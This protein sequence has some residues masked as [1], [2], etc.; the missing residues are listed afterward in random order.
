[1]NTPHS[2]WVDTDCGI[3]DA[4]ALI[5]L[6]AA[7]VTPAGISSVTGNTT[8]RQAAA[9]AA[10][11]LRRLGAPTPV[12]AGLDV[13]SSAGHHGTD[14]LG[15]TG[16]GDDSAV[17]GDDGVDALLAHVQRH[18]GTALLALGPATNLATALERDPALARRLGA[19]VLVAGAAEDQRDTNTA[20]DPAAM[21]EVAARLGPFGRLTVTTLSAT[22][23]DPI[24]GTA[25]ARLRS[26]PRLGGI[27]RPLVD[28]FTQRGDGGVPRLIAH[29]A[30]AAATLLRPG[31]VAASRHGDVAV[32][33]GRLV[34]YGSGRIRWVTALRGAGDR[35]VGTLGT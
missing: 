31:T 18:P 27:V 12:C 35:L 7:G 20:V 13:Q 17:S 6:V 8:A 28:A 10:G 21:A 33:D 4:L 16:L 22:A 5:H 23:S 34:P 32:R 24:T 25:L 19:V 26:G 11:I 2:L 29:D 9:N 14:G 1:V 3:D 15:G 30:L